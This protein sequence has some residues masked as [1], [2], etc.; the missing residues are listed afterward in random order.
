MN[1]HLH[2]AKIN[3][4]DEFYTRYEDIKRECDNYLEHFS[5]KVIYCNCDCER[6]EFRRYF[7]K[8]YSRGIIR[9]LIVTCIDPADGSP[10]YLDTENPFGV[11]LMVI[12]TPRKSFNSWKRQI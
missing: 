12:I 11:L 9:R 4:N 1:A 10:Y 5:G 3:R 6:S 2:K 8:L 7:L